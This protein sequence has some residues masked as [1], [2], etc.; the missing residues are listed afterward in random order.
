MPHVEW[1]YEP[2]VRSYLEM[3]LNSWNKLSH[4]SQVF[5]FRMIVEDLLFIR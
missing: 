1:R 3:F 2:K 4:A 5:L